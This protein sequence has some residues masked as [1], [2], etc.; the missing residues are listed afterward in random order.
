MKGETG[1]FLSLMDNPYKTKMMPKKKI[2]W[3]G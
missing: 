3:E 1:D 2:N